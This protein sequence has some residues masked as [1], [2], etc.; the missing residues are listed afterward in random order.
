MELC[1][2]HI[3][4]KTNPHYGPFIRN[5]AAFFFYAKN[6]GAHF[7]QQIMIR[8]DQLIIPAVNSVKRITETVK[9]FFRFSRLDHMNRE[10]AK[11]GGP[12]FCQNA[13]IEMTAGQ[14]KGMAN[15]KYVLLLFVKRIL[16]PLD[17]VFQPLVPLDIPVFVTGRDGIARAAAGNVN[18]E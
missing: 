16:I 3:I 14:L 13:R 9:Y 2:D 10:D 11:C 6:A 4:I 12:S 1:P 5:M 17:H 18:I 15:E 7:F 8:T